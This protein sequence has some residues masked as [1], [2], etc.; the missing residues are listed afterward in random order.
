MESK[1]AHSNGL[2]WDTDMKHHENDRFPVLR[3]HSFA[4]LMVFLGTVAGALCTEAETLPVP[5]IKVQAQRLDFAAIQRTVDDL[6]ANHPHMRSRLK[7]QLLE[8]NDYKETWPVV[9][10][11]L[12]TADPEA[13]AG[14][15]NCCP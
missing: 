3:S 11:G 2:M 9:L 5:T 12:K 4:A 10:T 8:I 14:P 6:S 1:Q 13:L 7:E 15:G